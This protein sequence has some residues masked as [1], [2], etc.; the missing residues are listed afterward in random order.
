MP[1]PR[2]NKNAAGKKRS[3]RERISLSLGIS[4]Q[5]G[6]LELF[7]EYLSRQGTPPTDENIKSLAR[8]LAYQSWAEWLKRQIEMSD[9]AIII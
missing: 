3:E 4:K 5:N 2:G 8:D 1:A 7:A 9:Q 6:L